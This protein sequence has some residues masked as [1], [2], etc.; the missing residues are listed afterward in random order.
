MNKIEFL[1]QVVDISFAFIE[2][3]QDDLDMHVFLQYL[4]AHL[5]Q[6][7]KNTAGEGGKLASAADDLGI[8]LVL[9]NR[10]AR[11]YVKIALE[12]SGLTTADEFSFLIALFANG[13][14][15]KSELIH[16][17]LL[18]KTSGTE[19]IK[20]LLKRKLIYEYDDV[21][22]KRSKRVEINDLGSAKVLELLPRISIS[23]DLIKG[24]LTA[25]ELNQL[26]RLLTKL[27]SH[28]KSVFEKNTKKDIAKHWPD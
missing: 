17:M 16:K 24:N 22:D 9:L 6:D 10:Y 8:K 12:N 18:T 20:R 7:S 11:E 13:S 28:H 5:S 21:N 26:N 27:E 23:S 25:S 14:H 1:K 3:T 4:E 15:T 2:G 19:V